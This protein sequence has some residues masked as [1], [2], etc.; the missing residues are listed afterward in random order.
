MFNIAIDGFVGSGKSTLSTEI[1]KRLN[2]KVL[3]TGA[4]YRGIACYYIKLALPSP[5]NELINEFV[6]DLNVEIKF[7][8]NIQN[9]IVNGE[10]FT[11]KLRDEQTSMMASLISPYQKVRN[12]VRLLQQNFASEND[13]IIEGRDIGTDVLPNAQVKLFLTGN[14]TIR[15]RRRLLQIKDKPNSPTYK[16]ILEDLKLRDYR[17]THR[18]VAP[19]KPAEDAIIIDSTDMNL[20]EMINFCVEIIIN[21]MKKSN[22][23]KN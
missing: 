23:S 11:N 7:I 22:I 19:L 12:K 6:K 13:C 16:E 3:D 10:N 1:A 15:A 5:N 18:E 4:I 9:V 17:D 2:L 21:K 20:E 8:E 14:A